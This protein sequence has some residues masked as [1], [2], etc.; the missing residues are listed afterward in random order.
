MTLLTPDSPVL[1]NLPAPIT[2]LIGRQAEIQ[3]LSHLLA[4]LATR[5][6]TMLAPGGMGKT[7]L[8]L[9]V[10]RQ[11]FQCFADGIYLV[12]VHETLDAER[13]AV[14]IADAIGWQYTSGQNV[15]Q[16]LLASLEQRE[17]L[18]IVDNA[19][20]IVGA[21]S[22][23]TSILINSSKIKILATSRVK[24]NLF[25]E[26]LF[27]LS[28]LPY[29]AETGDAGS[30]GVEA[31]ELFVQQAKK[32]HPN[33]LL[34]ADSL[35][36]IQ[37]IC[38]LV[39][40]MPLALVLAASWT[41]LLTPEEIAKEIRRGFD[42]LETDFQDVPER[43][44]SLRSIFDFTWRLL[45]GVDHQVFSRL[46]VFRQGFSLEAAQIVAQGNLQSF[47]N[48][49]KTA[50]L[51]ATPHEG[52]FKIHE[53]LRQY[54]A[55]RLNHSGEFN[56]TVAMHSHYF[57]EFI[58]KHSEHIKNQGQI[59]VLDALQA[60]EENIRAAWEWAVEHEEQVLLGN[61]LEGLFWYCVMRSR[62]PVFEALYDFTRKSLAF[63]SVP[64]VRLLLA[65][66][67]LRLL[68]IQRWREGSFVRYPAASEELEASLA[69]FRDFDAS[70]EI[71]MCMLLLGDALRTLTD[72]LERSTTLYQSAVQAFSDLGDDFYLAWAF[73]FTAK[74][75]SDTQGVEAG[76]KLLNQGLTLRRKHSDQIGATYSL[77]NLSTDYLL[78]GKLEAC[79][80]VTDEIL[81]ISQITGEQSTLLMAQI[82]GTFLAFMASHLE[83]VKQQNAVNRRLANSLNHTLGLAWVNLI[84][85]L[86]D[87]R[88]GQSENAIKAL[89]T[90][91]DFA[92]QTVIRYFVHLAFALTQQSDQAI[93]KRHL[94]SAMSHADRFSAFGA[95]IWCIPPLAVWESRHGQPVR[96]VELLALA[97]AQPSTLMGWL[98]R[99]LTQTLLP[100]QLETHLGR[101]TFTAAFERG[102]K[103]DVAEV[104]RSFLSTATATPQNTN[105]SL[106]PPHVQEANQ[107]MIEPLSDRELEV[108][109]Y[110]GRG[111]SNRE[112]ASELVVE[113]S[114]VKKHL[115]HIYDKLD[116][117]TR[118]KAILRAQELHL[119]W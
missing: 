52:R 83:D 98:S 47:R 100:E 4:D 114:T 115:T 26:T 37:E 41:D 74:L 86:I 91:E 42:V 49:L 28:G 61:A 68:W 107:H 23:L 21:A 32:V 79:K 30:G 3:A 103:L 43:Q 34:N 111:L 36:A 87:Y 75:M 73:H 13:L 95:Q 27:L 50:V 62:Y 10:A 72:D 92:T 69:V 119:I 46:S 66:M 24:L 1:T 7:V 104:I 118:A 51:Q 29:T 65:R 109:G 5:I 11:Q 67:Q 117:D 106:F 60:D 18:L 90:S 59:E 77:Y 82:T 105:K 20:Y 70:Q 53:L 58:G 110:I 25:A 81:T 9:E 102:R 45:E 84:Q 93:F 57:L 16:Q 17:L 40:G 56:A 31:V 78:L 113:L 96:A 2:P 101:G 108:L 33:F 64:N 112:I 54:A 76:I 48:L 88:D 44:R 71:A 97:E 22:Y 8:A 14:L 15:Q 116:V 85:G 39:Q 35:Q 6:I 12:T 63:V 55:E 80:N 89:A 99:W 38:R 19:E 94:F